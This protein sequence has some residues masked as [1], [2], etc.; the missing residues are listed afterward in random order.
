MNSSGRLAHSSGDSGWFKTFVPNTNTAQGKA[1]GH[2]FRVS[3]AT[4][5]LDRTIPNGIK[6]TR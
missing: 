6:G 1:N 5:A 4:T 3:H 2:R